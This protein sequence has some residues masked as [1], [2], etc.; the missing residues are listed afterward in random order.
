MLHRFIKKT[1]G[2]CVTWSTLG[3]IDLGLITGHQAYVRFVIIGT[4]RSGSNF[5]RGLL[6]AHPTAV[7]LGEIFREHGTIGWDI[8]GYPRS[9]KT[10]ALIEADP[11]AFL[12]QTLFRR[13]PKRL[14]AVGFKL[15]YHHARD[16]TWRSVWDYLKTDREIRIIHLKRKNMLKAYLSRCRANRT[17]SWVNTHGAEEA[18]VSVPLDY[19]DCLDS[20][21][22]TRRHE[23][24]CDT[25]FSRH[26]KLELTYEELASDY[27]EQIYRVQTFLGLAPSPVEPTTFKQS[28]EPLSRAISNYAELR[29][30]FSDTPW[31]DF[32]DN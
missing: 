31:A 2:A 24:A 10:L 18:A 11:V 13:Y 6:N 12:R 17:G 29:R 16:D 25:I 5:L 19:E 14:R 15:F 8:R 9:R 26:D 28:R 20:F 3:A 30:R 22:R 7:A 4:E 23:Q 1:T 27:V 32:F 21:E